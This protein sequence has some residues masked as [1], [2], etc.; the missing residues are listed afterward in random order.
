MSLPQIDIFQRLSVLQKAAKS[1]H[2]FLNMDELVEYVLFQ[3]IAIVRA[4][5]GMVALL[6][7]QADELVVKASSGLDMI[8]QGVR[9]GRN[10]GL[11]EILSTA[12]GAVPFSELE[13]DR[14]L[15]NSLMRDLGVRS[16]LVAPMHADSEVVGMLC[17]T[18]R[19][20]QDYSEVELHLMTILAE[21]AGAAI[22]KMHLVDTVNV[23]KEHLR[24]LSRRSIKMV[25]D[26]RRKIARELHDEVGQV[27]TALKLNLSVIK[28]RL[29]S[30]MRAVQEELEHTVTLASQS[31]EQVRTLSFELHPPMLQELGLIPTLQ[32]DVESI[33]LR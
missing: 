2:T 32:W 24:L 10:D 3:S 31:L 27:L 28:A 21:L 15:G 11:M 20:P 30:E 4:D 19:S 13:R 18:A 25:E 7:E 29:P 6:D 14:R 33:M 22:E 12:D 8:F 1:L 5:G 16:A 23:Q 9:Y 17:T 26:E